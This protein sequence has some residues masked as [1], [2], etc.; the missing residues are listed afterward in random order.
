VWAK[1]DPK[2]DTPHLVFADARSLRPV[3]GPPE[4]RD[5]REIGYL[6]GSSDY[7]VWTGVPK[8]LSS[9]NGTWF[10]DRLASGTVTRY[11]AVNHYFQFPELAGPYLMWFGSDKNSII[12]MRSGSG[13]DIPLPG[14]VEGSGDTIVIVKL[15]QGVSK[16]ATQATTISVV[17]P[18]QLSRLPAC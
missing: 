13:F 1:F 6:A 10:I 3:D 9:S 7:L 5:P 12:D 2:A 11:G 15:V 4:L 14:S 8:A 17:H 16:G 18:S